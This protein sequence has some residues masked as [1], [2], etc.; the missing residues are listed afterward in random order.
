MFKQQSL[1]FDVVSKIFIT[2]NYLVFIPSNILR[3]SSLAHFQPR[4]NWDKYNFEKNIIA[5]ITLMMY[6]NALTRTRFY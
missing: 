5:G 1:S 3:F 6:A 4:D 2:Q